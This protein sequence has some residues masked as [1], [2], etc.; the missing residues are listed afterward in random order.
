MHRRDL[1]LRV[2]LVPLFMTAACSSAALTPASPP[3]PA[4]RTA[5]QSTAV[6]TALPAQASQPSTGAGDALRKVT[7]DFAAKTAHYAPHFIAIDKGYYADERI[8][9]EIVGGGVAALLAGQSN[10]TTSPSSLLT[11]ILK[12]ANMKI[13]Y[14]NLDRPNYQLWSSQPGVRT[15]QDLP[16]KSV[17]VYSRGDT[18]EICARLLLI[19]AGLDPNGVAYTAL[20]SDPVVFSAVTAGSVTAGF[21]TVADVENLKRVGPKGSLLADTSKDVK[22]LFTGVGTS[23]KLLQ[24][25]PTLV[26]GFLRATIK[27]REYYKRY[28]DE[29][30]AILMKYNGGSRD[31]NSADYDSVLAT[32]TDDGTLSTEVAATDTKVR[33]S[34]IGVSTV[35]PLDEIYD[36]RL[37]QKIYAALRQSHWQPQR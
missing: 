3:T 34:L 36:Y 13:V 17:A 12:G 29:T 20:G 18:M 5:T 10:F 24:Q 9:L 11:A 27:G 35:R 16:G 25:E 1:L 19:K 26:E 14:T 32:M 22:M 7:A 4:P 15:L 2:G 33:A 23:D 37:V 30:V 8:A 28:K 6:N 31:A 21:L